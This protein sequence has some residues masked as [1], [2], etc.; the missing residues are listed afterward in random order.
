MASIDRRKFLLTAAGGLG[1]LGL[2]SCVDT[3]A[4]LTGIGAEIL[5]EVDA[6]GIHLRQNIYCM[7]DTHPDLVAYRKGVAVMKTRP[8]SDPTSWEAQR[9]IHWTTAP[10][11]PI[12][13]ECQHGTLFFFSWHRM[14]LYW[15]ERIVR[16]AAGAPSFAL[17]YWGYTPT[18]QRDLPAPFRIPADPALN[19]LYTASRN[20]A[21]NAGTPLT[22][23][24]VDPAAALALIPFTNFQ[25]SLEGTPHGQ[26]HVAVGG[27]MGSVPTAAL[28]PIFYLHHAQIDR[29]WEVWL[30]MGGGRAN[31]TTPPWTTDI[32]EFYDENGN[33][34]QMT[35]ADIVST[36]RQLCYRYISCSPVAVDAA[37]PVDAVDAQTAAIAEP[38]SR[39]PGRVAAEPLADA[40]VGV[41]LGALPLSVRVPLSRGAGVALRDL[42]AGRGGGN[43]VFARLD[44]LVLLQE[45]RVFYEVYANLPHAPEQATY[46]SPFYVGSL[47][48]FGVP[49]QGAGHAGHVPDH[50]GHGRR[51][52]LL[53]V[54]AYLRSRGLWRDGDVTLTFIPRGY[55]EGAEPTRLL[56]GDQAYIGRIAVAIQ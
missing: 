4:P 2:A 32:F 9:A 42:E 22:A 24:A 43:D 26:V 12:V 10:I 11:L 15:F 34:V 3:A 39:R 20:A 29:L 25:S 37:E 27:W 41:R 19:P 8:A 52:S 47:D 53:R 6:N 5:A 35:G 28:D 17:P 33:V 1:G 38:I 55:T 21:V 18:G 56:S 49:V 45:P 13:N 46:R 44:G 14:Y 40:Q 36:V 50:A 31:P 30:A 48:F 23:S 51:L 16:A 54:Y 7:K